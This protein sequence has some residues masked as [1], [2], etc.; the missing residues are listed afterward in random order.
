MADNSVVAHC[1]EL[2]LFIGAENLND[3]HAMRIV[4]KLHQSSVKF[5]LTWVLRPF[6][7]VCVEIS[8]VSRYDD[9]ANPITSLAY[10]KSKSF[11]I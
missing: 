5:F 9:N 1:N 3:R 2:V 11:K 4:A 7:S 8:V 10:S 6:D